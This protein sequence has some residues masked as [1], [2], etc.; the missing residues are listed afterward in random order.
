MAWCSD[1]KASDKESKNVV[2][3][4]PY[5][6]LFKCLKKKFFVPKLMHHPP[7]WL[8]KLEAGYFLCPNAVYCF[9]PVCCEHCTD[10]HP[11]VFAKMGNTISFDLS[12]ICQPQCVNENCIKFL[13]GA[14]HRQ[15][16]TQNGFQVW[17]SP[18]ESFGS[19]CW[20]NH[21]SILILIYETQFSKSRCAQSYLW[22]EQTK[23]SFCSIQFRWWDKWSEQQDTTEF[24]VYINTLIHNFV[25][26]S[27][28]LDS[29]TQPE[30]KP[31]ENNVQNE[32]GTPLYWV[33]VDHS[34]ND[35]MEYPLAWH[36]HELCSKGNN[37]SF[38]INQV[39]FA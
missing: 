36:R 26:L 29:T 5:T 20:C 3:A 18:G 37:F 23:T 38:E 33:L 7:V 24:G 19:C 9:Q 12:L 11:F 14:T 28:L 30:Q 10:Q 8:T 13:V 2:C 31:K 21:K 35:K 34:K 39:H 27:G 17:H 25:P 15:E 1:Y 32:S 16:W 22:M 4:L 6:C